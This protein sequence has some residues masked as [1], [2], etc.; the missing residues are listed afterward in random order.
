MKKFSFFALLAILLSCD[1]GDFNVPSF[2]FE[3]LTINN[4]GNLV[5]HKITS[6]STESLIIYLNEDNT[7]NIYF[8]TES[9]SLEYFISKDGE[10]TMSYRIFNGTVSSDYFCQ[11]IPSATPT[12]AEEWIGDGTL[13]VTNTIIYDDN[14]GVPL[15]VE[16]VIDENTGT[17]LDT[18]KDG[19]PNFIDDDDDGDNIP[20]IEEDIDITLIPAA[21]TGDPLNTDT[22]GD[23][24]KN[25]L[26]TDDDN[27][28]EPS[29]TES[30][31]A[32]DN[33]NTIPDYLD[34]A[35]IK[36]IPEGTPIAN[37]YTLSYTML[38]EFSTLALRGEAG[39][40]NYPDGYIY[41]TKTGSFEDSILP[42]FPEDEE[43]EE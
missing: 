22:D 39:D 40:I 20:T 12:V 1:D 7:E 3:G 41:G 28:G 2:D 10:H 27:D 9:D 17:W 18:D 31:A 19:F 11:D 43:V 26:D 14:D 30:K 8:K 42:T 5:L 29:I 33:Q 21:A 13:Y 36:P 34:A 32:D 4:C 23:G 16:K 38:F 24:I 37:N 35:T 15:E 25:Y 6:S